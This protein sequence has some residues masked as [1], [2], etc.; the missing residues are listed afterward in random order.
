MARIR[1]IKPEFPQ[2]ESMGRVSRDARLLFVMLWPICDDHGRTRA[3]SRMLASLLFPYDD[4]APS[5]VGGWLDELEREG[6]IT[7][8]TVNGSTFLQVTNWL[9][10]QKID[11]PSKPQFP[12]PPE[13][14][15]NPREDSSL[16]G[17][18]KEG[19]GKEARA[20]PATP[21]PPAASVIGIPLNDGTD[22]PITLDQVEEFAGLYP[23]VDVMAELRK[24]RGWCVTNPT[25]R[26]TKTGVMKF[27]NHWLAKQQDAGPSA[28]NRTTTQ[29]TRHD[30]STAARNA[31]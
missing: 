21:T 17:K 30:E 15:A 7:R 4:D 12:D 26:K 2:S 16:E 31:L 3:A 11:K 14:F 23:A 13:G 6:C 24:M 28:H 5:L 19:K 1:T 10:H 25:K 22:H 9:I 18:G 20:T 29:S 8:Y 27:V